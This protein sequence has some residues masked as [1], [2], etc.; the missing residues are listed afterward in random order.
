MF[1]TTYQL[2]K[3]GRVYNAFFGLLFFGLA[4]FVLT[5]VVER[6]QAGNPLPW[7]EWAFVLPVFC[8]WSGFGG[9]CMLR[10]LA[11]ANRLLVFGDGIVYRGALKQL[12][13]RWSDI[14]SIRVLF[15]RGGFEWLEIIAAN[16]KHK[17][18][19]SGV[20]PDRYAF[21]REVSILAPNV[22]VKLS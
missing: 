5:A 10:A 13:L 21:L 19:L 14:R 2:T 3:R 6:Y 4:A 11:S 15:D 9:Y 12:Q 8:L 16:S 7:P 22:L 20:F 18:D 17:I 1:S